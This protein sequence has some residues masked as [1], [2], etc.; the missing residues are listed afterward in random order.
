MEAVTEKEHPVIS[1]IK[2]KLRR[3]GAKAAMMSGSGSTV[4]GLF[5]DYKKAFRSQ[6]SFSRMYQEVYLT[7]TN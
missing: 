7:H 3:N 4:F 5:D 2:E 1:G 6:E